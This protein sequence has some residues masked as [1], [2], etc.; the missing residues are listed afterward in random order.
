MGP[1]NRA[2]AFY[3]PAPLFAKS[4]AHQ[5]N[6]YN[7][8]VRKNFHAPENCPTAPLQKIIFNKLQFVFLIIKNLFRLKANGGFNATI[9]GFSFV[10]T[11][12]L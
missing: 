1:E 6:L 2:S 10:I 7:L 3:Y 12:L 4:I 8:R 11:N 5:K 9:L